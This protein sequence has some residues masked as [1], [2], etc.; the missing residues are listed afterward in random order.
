M[1]IAEAFACGTRIV[2]SR[3]GS[4]NEIINDEVTGIKFSAGDRSSQS[5]AVEIYCCRLQCN[6]RSSTS[7]TRP[8]YTAERNLAQLLFIYKTGIVEDKA[9]G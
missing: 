1:A 6:A 9:R 8:N 7:S 4:L 3:T 2:A 5:S